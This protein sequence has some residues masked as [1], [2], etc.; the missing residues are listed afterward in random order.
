M[1]VCVVS[2]CCVRQLGSRIA[3]TSTTEALCTWRS[4]IKAASMGP[5]LKSKL[6]EK[7]EARRTKFDV[8]NI[9]EVST[10]KKCLP[11]VVGC[12]LQFLY[13]RRQHTAFYRGVLL[14]A[15]SR[16]WGGAFSPKQV[17]KAVLSWAWCRHFKCTGISCPFDFDTLSL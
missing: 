14:R 12:S 4:W 11:G 9:G 1:L 8:I 7:S 17:L 10:I 2:F 3:K 16:T 5:K 13:H 6:K 15:R